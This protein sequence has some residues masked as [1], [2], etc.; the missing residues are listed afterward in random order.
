[1]ETVVSVATL[2]VL[3]QAH[4]ERWDALW[5]STFTDSGHPT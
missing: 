1:V 5:V 3:E 4:M 2:H